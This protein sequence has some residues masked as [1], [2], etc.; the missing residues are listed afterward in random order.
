MMGR[1]REKTAIY[2]ARREAS[3]GANPASTLLSDSELPEL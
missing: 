1:H 2:T 3:E